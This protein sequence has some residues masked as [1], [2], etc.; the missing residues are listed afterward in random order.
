MQNFQ[1]P[2][3]VLDQRSPTFYPIAIVAIQNTID[4]PHFGAMYV[5]AQN[6]VMPTLFSLVGYGLLK[7]GHVIQRSFDF[8]LEV[9]RQ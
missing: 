7:V 2:V 8:L 5:A 9:G 1:T 3:I 4:H 6:A